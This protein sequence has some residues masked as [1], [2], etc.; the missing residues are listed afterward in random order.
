MS[1]TTAADIFVWHDLMSTDHETAI[2]FYQRL[3]GWDLDIVDMGEQIGKYSMFKSEGD[4]LGGVVPLDSEHGIPSHWISY[5]TVDDVDAACKKMEEIGGK[6][7]YKPFDI[8]NVGRTAVAQDP[9]GAYF[10]PYKDAPK[11]DV[12]PTPAPRAG[13]FTW[14][15][16]MS[17]DIEKAK[18]FY[19]E[20]MGWGIG[21]MDMGPAGTYWLFKSDDTDIAG[22]VQMPAAAGE[23]AASNWLPYVGVTSVPETTQRA[24][25]LGGSVYVEP[26]QISEPAN[27][28]FAILAGPDGS[29]FGIVEV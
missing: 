21:S 27:V 6:V 20:I 4:G 12:P 2:K 10:S 1:T 25:D 19:A 29:M 11:E 26:K 5:I 17:T 13:L 16:L 8:P 23:N 15:E 9:A 7:P 3:F 22:A 18:P 28:H 24:K 14:H